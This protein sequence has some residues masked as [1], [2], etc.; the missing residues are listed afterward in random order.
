VTDVQFNPAH[1]SSL[2]TELSLQQSFEKYG[3]ILNVSLPR[4]TNNRLK[5]YAFIHYEESE[6]GEL[7]A[8]TAIAEMNESGYL[9][10]MP[11]KLSY[12]KRQIFSRYRKATQQAAAQAAA[13]AAAGVNGHQ[14]MNGM[15]GGMHGGQSSGGNRGQGGGRNRHNNNA[16]GHNQHNGY[17]DH[18][19]NHA[20]HANSSYIH[21]HPVAH[22]L[23]HSP[24]HLPHH[25]P[26][27]YIPPY[28]PPVARPVASTPASAQSGHA[29]SSNN[30]AAAGAQS[31]VMAINPQTGQW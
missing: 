4:Y 3:Q 20:H 5:G 21:G 2:L 17:Y 22:D 9:G 24:H 10:S 8:A 31:W 28:G 15:Y 11:I 30:Q 1:A 16:N 18:H 6:H 26:Y 12:G 7:S 23:H 13:A 25:S 27:P 19:N 29:H 14:M